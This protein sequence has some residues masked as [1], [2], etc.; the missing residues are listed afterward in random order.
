MLSV[1]T[2][3]YLFGHEGHLR[4]PK[5]RSV[6][7]VSA[8][9]QLETTELLNKRNSTQN[10]NFVKAF[11]TWKAS[12]QNYVSHNGCVTP[13]LIMLQSSHNLELSIQAWSWTGLGWNQ[14]TGKGFWPQKRSITASNSKC[15]ALLLNTMDNQL[16]W[17]VGGSIGLVWCNCRCSEALLFSP[18]LSTR[19]HGDWLRET[20][21][22]RELLPI[23][24]ISD[25]ALFKWKLA[26]DLVCFCQSGL[27][28]RKL[29]SGHEI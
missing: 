3:F 17:G 13:H 12:H 8:I 23:N 9:T 25:Q 20:A 5:S 27:E 28:V 21:A 19:V 2:G 14:Y 1:N 11:A 10:L 15:Q 4:A 7:I 6:I 18:A 16:N 24:T 29:S 22:R 26:T